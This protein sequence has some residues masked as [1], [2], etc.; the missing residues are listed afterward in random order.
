MRTG[1]CISGSL[2]LRV[3]LRSKDTQ[4]YSKQQYYV[5]EEENDNYKRKVLYIK[6][7]HKSEGHIIGE[8]NG[9]VI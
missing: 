1:Y 7:V 8:R 5:S 4:L 3:E 6:D 9:P 2:E